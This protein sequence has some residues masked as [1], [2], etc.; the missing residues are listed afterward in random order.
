MVLHL[1]QWLINE[2]PIFGFYIMRQFVEIVDLFLSI[3]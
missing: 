3:G 1:L 2:F